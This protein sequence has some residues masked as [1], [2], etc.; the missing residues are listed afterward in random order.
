MNIIKQW[1]SPD[2]KNYRYKTSVFLICLMI[3]TS[4]WLL[5]KFAYQYPTE[6][7]YPVKLTGLPDD[8]V[9]IGHA[10][11]VSR[12]SFKASG[13]GLLRFQYFSRKQPF[14]INLQN[15]RIQ[16][17]SDFSELT[18][19]TNP[20]ARQIMESFNLSGSIEYVTPENLV[21][22]FEERKSKSVA[23]IP[24][25]GLSFMK[26]FFAYDSLSVEPQ[27]VVVSGTADD[28]SSVHFVKTAPLKFDNLSASID[29][30]VNI[31]LPESAKSIRI[32]PD[33]VRLQLQVEKF[34]EAEIEIPI[35][36][37]NL[38]DEM[39]VKL[40]P[41]KVRVVYMVALKDFKKI[42]AG[43]FS[44]VVDLS[45]IRSFSGKRITVDLINYPDYIKIVRIVPPDLE[46]IILK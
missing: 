33:H 14:E 13:F 39:R 25:V 28:I 31:D 6:I 37:I 11:S 29:Q 41:E 3:S 16:P 7:T 10:N 19:G 12:I 36:K 22:R 32:E 5:E 4:V 30:M 23:V 1:I 26:Q 43:K 17:Q 21:L 34:T 38:P 27:K 24:V 9:L 40:F 2:G 15:Y 8:K 42:D 46:Y 18:I 45:K 35:E 44:C 20:F